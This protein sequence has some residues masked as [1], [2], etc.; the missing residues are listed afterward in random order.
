VSVAARTAAVLGHEL[1][2]PLGGALA[3]AAV[4]REMVDDADPRRPVL[5]AV[6]R[7]LER[8]GALLDSY[9]AFARAGRPAQGPVA[10]ADLAAAL[11]AGRPQVRATAPAD[12]V[13]RGD[14]QL[15]ARALEN[16]VENALQAGARGVAIAARAAG[17]RA[18]LTVAD[19]GPGIPA[20][21][22]ERIFEPGFSRRGGTGLGLSIVAETIAAHGGSVRCEA[23]ARGSRFVLDLP[24]HREL[25]VA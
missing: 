13:V 17:G 9:L 3:N 5:D 2:N 10:V 24:L 12:L 15:L 6:M 1:R 23:C 21:L 18:L 14:A 22:R 4:L 16:L 11:A 8:M 7:D 25:S 19:D 20:E